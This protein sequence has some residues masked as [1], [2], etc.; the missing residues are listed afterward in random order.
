M[1]PKTLSCTIFTESPR[2]FV[3]KKRNASPTRKAGVVR[4]RGLA[5]ELVD[6]LGRDVPERPE[7]ALR[8]STSSLV[9][10]HGLEL[11]AGARESL[12]DFVMLGVGGEHA[13]VS[14]GRLR[15]LGEGDVGDIQQDLVEL[16]GRDC[17]LD[18]DELQ[19]GSGLEI[20]DATFESSNVRQGPC[21]HGSSKVWGVKIRDRH[22]RKIAE[23]V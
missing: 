19:V 3:V 20:S 10:P 1:F 12:D 7:S 18:V 21:V 2:K 15:R 8:R 16:E 17:S 23:L 13:R 5:D 4:S 6:Q 22:G 11:L 9:V 14:R